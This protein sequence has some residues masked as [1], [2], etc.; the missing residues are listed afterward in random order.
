MRTP[1]LAAASLMALALAS[2]APASAE[3]APRSVGADPRIQQYTY[4]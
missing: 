1:L 2:A 4:V 3:T